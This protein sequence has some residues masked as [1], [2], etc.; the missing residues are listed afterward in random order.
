MEYLEN[1]DS[2]I[3]EAALV[4][5]IDISLANKGRLDY[6]LPL[7]RFTDFLFEGIRSRNKKITEFT[8]GRLSHWYG[9]KVVASL[10]DVLDSVDDNERRRIADVL[11]DA[12]PSSTKVI[13]ER[14]PAASST[15]KLTLLEIVRQFADEDIGQRLLPYADD[16]DPEVRQRIAHVL[17]ISGYLDAVPKLRQLAHDEI[18][19]VRGAAY[20]ALGWLCG[21]EDIDFLIEGLDDQYADVR[22]AAMGAMII[23]GGPRVIEKFTED[24]FHESVERQRLATTALGLIG[25]TDVVEPLFKAAGHPDPSIRK[26]ALNSLARIRNVEKVEMI[27]PALS[28]ESSAVRKAAVT[29]LATIKGAD[30]VSDIRFLLDDED[31]WVRYHAINTIGELG[32]PQNSEVILPYLND[33]NDVIKIAAVKA[34]AQMKSRD[35]LPRLRQLQ[36]D[37]NRDVA[38]AVDLAVG[39]LEADS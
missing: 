9:N 10:I 20:A 8:L 33:D 26:Q 30:A 29:A 13:L 31:V 34:L 5:I 15:T 25:D 28:D 2:S 7:D 18:G 11:E 6:D 1:S 12:G 14:F 16:P 3:A 27:V 17:G 36:D 35:A 37:R 21:E 32:L 23:V 22:E 39:D 38:E 4:A 19:H 24:L